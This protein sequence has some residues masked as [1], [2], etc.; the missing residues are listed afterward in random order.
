M[1]RTAILVDAGHFFAHSSTLL[2]GSKKSRKELKLDE[3]RFLQ[4]LITRGLGIS[5]TALLRVYWYDAAVGASFQN[6]LSVGSCPNL[7][8]R[9]GYINHMG[10]QKLVDSLMVSDLTELARNRA[11]SDI[12]VVAGDE[13][14]CPGVAMAQSFGVRVHLMKIGKDDISYAQ[15]LMLEVDTVDE[16][17]SQFIA[18]FFTHIPGSDS[19]SLTAELREL[20]TEMVTQ[21]PATRRSNMALETE[22]KP[23]V[24]HDLDSM[25]L[26][27]SKFLVGRELTSEEKSLLRVCFLQEI[28]RKPA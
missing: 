15:R 26:T 18:P 28:N 3:T 16:L 10:E 20:V 8:L 22:L 25:L 7:K 5:G 23:G 2:F 4:A 9:L 13:D 21:V 24:P 19:C 12:V 1:D 17:D 27:K 11:V 14:I 6:H